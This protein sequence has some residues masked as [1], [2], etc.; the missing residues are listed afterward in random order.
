MG[1]FEAEEQSG[2]AIGSKAVTG[3]EQELVREL[4]ESMML[5][6][7]R[8]DDG[9]VDQGPPMINREAGEFTVRDLTTALEEQLGVRPSRSTIRVALRKRVLEGSYGTGNRRQDRITSRPTAYAFWKIRE[10]GGALPPLIA[11]VPQDTISEFRRPP[12]INR[13]KGEFFP[14]DAARELGISRPSRQYA[15]LSARL[16]RESRQGLLGRER[17]TADDGKTSAYAYWKIQDD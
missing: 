2:H 10:D 6:R 14:R 8:I 9:R 11:G 7:R 1:N 15:N 12:M 4:E 13:E 16:H 17:R 3:F 5:L